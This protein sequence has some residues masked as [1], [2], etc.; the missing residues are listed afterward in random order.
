MFECER[1]GAEELLACDPASLDDDGVR[2]LLGRLDALRGRA[3]AAFAGAVG[4]SDTRGL[5]ANDGA[6]TPPRGWPG[7]ACWAGPRPAP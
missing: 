1:G 6:C 5:W 4:E 3:E 2:A 7:A